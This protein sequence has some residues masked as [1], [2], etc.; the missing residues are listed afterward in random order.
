MSTTHQVTEVVDLKKHRLAQLVERRERLGK[1]W[2]E[3]VSHSRPGCEVLAYEL[4]LVERAITEQWPGESQQWVQ[5]WILTDANRLHD[6][7]DHR[8]ECSFCAASTRPARA[9]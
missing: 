7:G 9:A 8:P 2:A 3:R 1:A 6:P 4:A 5:Q